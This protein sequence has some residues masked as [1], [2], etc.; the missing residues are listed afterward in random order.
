MTATSQRTAAAAAA[1]HPLFHQ[2]FVAPPVGGDG[3][4]RPRTARK[5]V[6]R[7]IRPRAPRTARS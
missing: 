6:V 7:T 1:V 4:P 5:S 2:L 3:R